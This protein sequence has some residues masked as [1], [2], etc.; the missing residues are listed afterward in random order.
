MKDG[1]CLAL[2]KSLRPRGTT[3]HHYA[4]LTPWQS[5]SENVPENPM[6]SN[7]I[8]HFPLFS[9]H[10]PSMSHH[11]PSWSH[12]NHRFFHY[13]PPIFHQ[14]TATTRP[15]PSACRHPEALPG[16]Q[17][18]GPHPNQGPVTH[19]DPVTENRP[20]RLIC[21]SQLDLLRSK[22]DHKIRDQEIFDIIKIKDHP[23]FFKVFHVLS[24]SYIAHHKNV[25]MLNN[26]EKEINCI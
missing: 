18:L 24:R 7:I 8:H 11:F 4:P 9:H 22:S 23:C 5:G 12:W 10:F 3:M 15:P 6:L 19:G 14:P 17:D 16:L 13:I 2:R 25:N 1:R 21:A 20:R 26:F